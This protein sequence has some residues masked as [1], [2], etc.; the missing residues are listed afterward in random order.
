[1]VN[2][3][4]ELSAEQH[5]WLVTVVVLIVNTVTIFFDLNAV[6]A[7]ELVRAE[8]RCCPFGLVL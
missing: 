1:M 4:N 3:N 6:H 7:K 8:Q 2:A 5:H